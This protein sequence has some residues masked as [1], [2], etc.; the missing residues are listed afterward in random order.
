[1]PRGKKGIVTKETISIS[2]KKELL[3]KIDMKRGLIPRSPY[4]EF[5][6]ENLE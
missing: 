2:I 6:L 3:L 4:I 5:L 1:M